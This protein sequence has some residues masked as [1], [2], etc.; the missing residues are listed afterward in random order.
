MYIYIH[1]FKIRRS[2]KIYTFKKK[3]DFIS[4]GGLHM[5]YKPLNMPWKY[6]FLLC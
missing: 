4:Y 1:T 2:S 6:L 3:K 5:L